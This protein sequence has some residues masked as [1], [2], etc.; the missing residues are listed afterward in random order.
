M[1]VDTV[2]HTK[3]VQ[4]TFNLSRCRALTSYPAAI[5][6]DAKQRHGINRHINGL[7][8]CVCVPKL[9]VSLSHSILSGTFGWD[10]GPWFCK[11]LPPAHLRGEPSRAGRCGQHCA[12]WV[13]EHRRLAGC[14]SHLSLNRQHSRTD[15]KIDRKSSGV[16]GVGFHNILSP[17]TTSLHSDVPKSPLSMETF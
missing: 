16:L 15:R 2:D 8:W 5:H 10:C 6:K 7:Q 3:H 12:R 4:H 14:A 17:C 1:N 9:R 11:H 13:T